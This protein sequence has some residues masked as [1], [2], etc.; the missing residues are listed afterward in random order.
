MS[1]SDVVKFYYYCYLTTINISFART[2]NINGN[3][4]KNLEACFGCFAESPASW[5][6]EIL[7]DPLLK[8]SLHLDANKINC[9]LY[10]DNMN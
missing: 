4:A 9:M 5:L 2:K 1:F 6:K 3:V 10:Y 8:L 7:S